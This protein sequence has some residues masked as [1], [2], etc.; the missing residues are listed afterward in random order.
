MILFQNRKALN[1]PDMPAIVAEMHNL[2]EFLH[3]GA[4]FEGY[5][6][7]AGETEARNVEARMRMKPTELRAKPPWET[8]DIPDVKQI[9]DLYRREP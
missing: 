8:Q 5:R 1:H 9:L 2:N 6:R 4:A 3:K 7:S